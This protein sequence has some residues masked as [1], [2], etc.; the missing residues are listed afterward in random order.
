[1][2]CTALQCLTVRVRVRDL[3]SLEKMHFLWLQAQP[4]A[5]LRIHATL[6]SDSRCERK[7]FKRMMCIDCMHH[8]HLVQGECFRPLKAVQ[9]C[10]MRAMQRTTLTFAGGSPHIILPWGPELHLK[11]QNP[12]WART[13]ITGKALLEASR[14]VV[15]EKEP[16]HELRL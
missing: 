12:A 1:M 11:L 4:C 16:S 6:G 2:L 7:L 5:E 3:G 14:C 13:T 15:I 10:S 8:S 9:W